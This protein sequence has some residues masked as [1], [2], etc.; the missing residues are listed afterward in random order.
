M[1]EMAGYE[2]MSDASPNQDENQEVMSDASQVMSDASQVMSQANVF[3]KD[4]QKDS[5]SLAAGQAAQIASRQTKP[6]NLPSLRSAEPETVTVAIDP[7]SWELKVLGKGTRPLVNHVVQKWPLDYKYA[8]LVKYRNRILL[9]GS[10]AEEILAS[11]Y[12][13]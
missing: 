9:T 10:Q 8:E 2:V 12:D 3:N 7:S 13:V 4:L 1:G 11:G 5:Q 6:Q